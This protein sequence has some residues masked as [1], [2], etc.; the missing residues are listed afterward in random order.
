[1]SI[2][3]QRDVQKVLLCPSLWRNNGSTLIPLDPPLKKGEMCECFRKG[4]RVSVLEKGK[5]QEGEI[6][7]RNRRRESIK[8]GK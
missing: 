6:Q 2:G 5:M 3:M 8:E 4:K 1:M 7:E